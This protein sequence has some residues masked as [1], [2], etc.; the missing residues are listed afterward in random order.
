[1]EVHK[2]KGKFEIMGEKK[3]GVKK[4]IEWTKKKQNLREQQIK[5]ERRSSP[6]C[7]RGD[8]LKTDEVEFMVSGEGR[9]RRREKEPRKKK[10]RVSARKKKITKMI[11]TIL[12]FEIDFKQHY[13]GNGEGG[14]QDS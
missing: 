9:L 7:Q 6:A 2:K 8:F 14:A 11:G 10:A 3:R 1:V 13:R 5:P 12:R 4:E